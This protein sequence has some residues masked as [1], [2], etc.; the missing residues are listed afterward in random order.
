MRTILAALSAVL[1][2]LSSAAV[3]ANDYKGPIEMI[4]TKDGTI[5]Y[6]LNQDSKEIAVVSV[7]DA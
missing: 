2:A 1:F 3:W 7:A 5:L 6:V 4:P